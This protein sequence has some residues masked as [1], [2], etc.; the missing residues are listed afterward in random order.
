MIDRYVAVLGA[1]LIGLSIVAARF[2]NRYEIAAGVDAGGNPIA[3][4]LNTRTGEVQICALTPSDNPF[5]KFGAPVTKRTNVECADH[6]GGTP[7]NE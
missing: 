2:V 6:F 5:D 7:I 3:W 4:R 1:L